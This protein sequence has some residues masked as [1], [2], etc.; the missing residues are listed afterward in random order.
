[1]QQVPTREDLLL[2]GQDIAADLQIGQ[3]P[4]SLTLVVGTGLLGH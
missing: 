4:D 3:L 2:L 1:M